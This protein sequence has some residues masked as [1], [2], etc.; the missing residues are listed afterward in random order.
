[1]KGHSF[2]FFLSKPVDNP[3]SKRFL[4]QQ[5]HPVVHRVT[6]T[7]G[8]GYL[9]KLPSISILVYAKSRM[10]K[11]LHRQGTPLRLDAPH[12]FQ[13]GK[14][15]KSVFH[16][17]PIGARTIVL[18]SNWD[19]SKSKTNK[20]P[21]ARSNFFFGLLIL[22]PV[23]SFGLGTWQVKRLQWKL[24]LISRAEDRLLLPPIDLPPMVDAEAANEFDYRRVRVSG[25]FDH[26]Q[27]MLVGPRLYRDRRGYFVVTPLKRENASTLL[28]FR[29]WIDEAHK[30]QSSRPDSLVEGVVTL[31]CLLHKKP[32]KNMFTP[33]P[34]PNGREYH[35]MAIDDM[36]Q[37]TGSQ[38]VYIEALL[39]NEDLMPEQMAM[40][41]IPIGGSPKVTYRNSHFQY[42]LTWYGLSLF[43][44][45]MLMTILKQRRAT[46]I[47]PLKKKLA[48]ARKWQ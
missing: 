31:D 10:S 11:F 36:A 37:A 4:F 1:M 8:N 27:E 47:D 44:S 45:I 17:V 18:R 33:P 35:F 30:F 42:I 13:I 28:V 26:T 29:G 38:P 19:E 7:W 6:G 3:G 12:Y 15:S 14:L 21:G 34:E 32:D 20:K 48:H 46:N 5:N 2:S 41:G 23:V 25:S 22:M 16:R 39:E 24:D 40:R 9:T 43:T